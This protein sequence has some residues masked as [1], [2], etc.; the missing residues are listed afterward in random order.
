M[1]KFNPELFISSIE[2]NKVTT[3]PLVPFLVV[4]LSQTPL[5]SK[6]NL[7]SLKRII[8]GAA[9]LSDKQALAL[10]EILP[11]TILSQGFGMTELSPVAIYD[12]NGS[13]V[14]S[15][16]MPI[17]GT[18]C[19]VILLL[20]NNLK[21]VIYIHIYTYLSNLEVVLHECRFG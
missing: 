10:K 1:T 9:P 18:E 21:Y 11:N 6:Y 17:P 20:L 13:D 15:V 3:L 19:K 5:R 14:A 4:F 12:K 16:G 2:K 7:D 8:S